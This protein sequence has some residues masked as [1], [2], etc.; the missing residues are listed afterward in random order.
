VT[1]PSTAGSSSKKIVEVEV[2][3]SPLEI[4]CKVLLAAQPPRR[5]L[6]SRFLLKKSIKRRK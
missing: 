4:T 5:I 3:F 6:N 1:V 2:G